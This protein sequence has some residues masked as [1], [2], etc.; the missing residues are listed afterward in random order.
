MDNKDYKVDDLRLKLQQLKGHTQNLSKSSK[1]SR[2]GRK[3]KS[4]NGL[5]SFYS[6]SSLE[7]S[8]K[9]NSSISSCASR[10]FSIMQKM[11][12]SKFKKRS[13]VAMN[14]F[15]TKE[16]RPKL[17][18]LK[19]LKK[20]IEE[21]C[22]AKREYDKTWE[23]S[24]LPLETMEQYLY[25]YMNQ[26]YGLKSLVID[27]VMTVVNSIQVYS[28]EGKFQGI[29]LCLDPDPDVLVFGRILKNECEEGFD[30]FQHYTREIIDNIVKELIQENFKGHTVRQ[31]EEKHN[32]IINGK[33][34][35]YLWKNILERLFDQETWDLITE[36]V[37]VAIHESR[38][39]DRYAIPL[40]MNNSN[41][42]KPFKASVSPRLKSMTISPN[43]TISPRCSNS[44]RYITYTNFVNVVLNFQLD[45][46][47][48]MI[49][50]INKYF[51]EVDVSLDGSIDRSQLSILLSKLTITDES[52]ISSITSD[53]DPNNLNY[54]TY[55]Q[56]LK[57]SF[58]CKIPIDQSQDLVS[59]VDI[60][61]YLT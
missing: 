38:K 18:P 16:D 7:S 24:N 6:T 11:H 33:L 23:E 31:V 43:R 13:S 10:T 3:E 55:S 58:N 57:Y 39:N 20:I 44:S 4:R 52:T 2:K 56:F 29:N 9:L 35:T 42:K 54:I 32:S 21:I 25:T 37:L 15:K 27:W 50:T 34:D 19:N 12:E 26:K 30:K 5:K 41:I 14:I 45:Q 28:K 8:K 47:S 59:L 48:K 22:N 1:A 49:T 40:Q 60:A 61:E 36:R 46:H 53:L 51:K 17:L